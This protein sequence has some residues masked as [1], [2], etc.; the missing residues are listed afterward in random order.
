[1]E[2]PLDPEGGALETRGPLRQILYYASALC[3]IGIVVIVFYSSV[4]RY[5][6]SSPPFWGE[7]VPI[8]L[9]VWMGFLAAGLAIVS[10]WNV[11]VEV[12]DML[13]PK[14]ATL[15]LR[16]V[17]HV[18]VV[19]FLGLLVYHSWDVFDLSLFGRLQA[20]GWPRWVPTL[21]LLTGL[22]LML[23]FQAVLLLR[24]IRAL[25]DGG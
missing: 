18:I 9:F 21:A 3:L 7:E 1:M 16:L 11:R 25:R 2:Q 10:G 17:M 22:V 15:L 20:T 23:W 4:A 19:V 12:V 5:F 14:R 6:F 13:L 8:I 24:T